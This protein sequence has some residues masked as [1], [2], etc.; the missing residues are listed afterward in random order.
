MFASA[1]YQ[2]ASTWRHQV[3]KA[4]VLRCFPVVLD[5]SRPFVQH[6]LSLPFISS[7]VCPSVSA[8]PFSPY[9]NDMKLTPYPTCCSM[10]TSDLALA[11]LRALR[12]TDTIHIRLASIHSRSIDDDSYSFYFHTWP[13]GCFFFSVSWLSVWRKRAQSFNWVRL[14]LWCRDWRASGGDPLVTQPSMLLC[15]STGPL[16]MLP[17]DDLVYD[18]PETT[19]MVYKFY[20]N[21]RNYSL[22][23]D[24]ISVFCFLSLQISRQLNFFLYRLSVRESYR[25][26]SL[27]F[28]AQ[29]VN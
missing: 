1:D 4:S 19:Q 20:H 23:I 13:S 10:S 5:S 6:P 25:L 12:V 17:L 9:H 16:T 15:F 22:T 27:F 11:T 26:L 2:G 18:C 7:K 24:D 3:V 21:C 28:Y 14:V 29:A 8:K